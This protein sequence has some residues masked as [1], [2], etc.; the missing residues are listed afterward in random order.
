LLATVVHHWVQHPGKLFF[1]FVFQIL[2]APLLI[3]SRMTH[4]SVFQT[5]QHPL[6]SQS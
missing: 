3:S 6:V 4:S 2:V 5:S 1:T